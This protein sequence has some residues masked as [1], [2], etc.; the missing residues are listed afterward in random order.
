MNTNTE[1]KD[2]TN[3]LQ[4][5]FKQLDQGVGINASSVDLNL[6]LCLDENGNVVLESSNKITLQFLHYFDLFPTE[7]EQKQ[8][9][10]SYAFV[11]Q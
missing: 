9:E 10:R 11:T 2:L 4:N 6:E 5:L 8:K 1:K 3:Y 7:K